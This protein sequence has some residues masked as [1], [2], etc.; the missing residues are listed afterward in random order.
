MALL[1]LL[2]PKE[3]IFGL[4]IQETY[5]RA[6]FLYYTR[7]GVVTLVSLSEIKLP[8]GTILRGEVKNKEALV[9]A[10]KKLLKS[11][12][13]SI[14]TPYCVVS[15]P[16]SLVFTQ[17]FQF[18]PLPPEAIKEAI[19]SNASLYPYP[20]NEAYTDW[21]EV[22]ALDGEGKKEYLVA[23]APKNKINPYL[24]ILSEINLIPV[25]LEM[26]SLS[27][28]HIVEKA[29]KGATLGVCL[30]KD[31]I[32]SL[33]FEREDL[34]FNR[35][36]SFREEIPATK[37]I[38]LLSEEVK[39]LLLKE[40]KRVIDF[41]QSQRK[42]KVSFSSLFVCAEKSKAQKLAKYLAGQLEIKVV[43]AKPFINIGKMDFLSTDPSWLVA[44][45]SALRGLVPRE[46]DT[47][48]SL[49]PVGT[50]EAYEIK[51]KIAFASLWKNIIVSVCIVLIASFLGTW[52]LLYSLIQTS[53]Q[54]LNRLASL[55]LPKGTADLERKALEFNERIKT[56]KELQKEILPF[57]PILTEIRDIKGEGISLLDIRISSKENEVS[58]SGKADT[59]D[60]LLAFKRDLENSRF[61]EN[62]KMPL[63]SLEERENIEFNMSFNFI[64]D[65]LSEK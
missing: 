37:K 39:N 9:Q 21:Q 7:K 30:T 38:N 35:F 54:Q 6:V 16:E 50:E 48:I 14:R 32:V 57:S 18:P 56:M 25:A 5:L 1:N 43:S 61:F 23:Q 51:K 58:L 49:L 42:T 53:D 65:A 33:V 62:I 3:K 22:K 12:K 64:K 15:L 20:L 29:Q 26:P 31:G 46:E 8:K 40:I 60:D 63:A 44:T 52:F 17:T 4:E 13:P 47:F 10:L 19:K 36:L 28:S 45:G 41:Y 55:P 24:E 11:A 2:I 34:R 27:L 59:R